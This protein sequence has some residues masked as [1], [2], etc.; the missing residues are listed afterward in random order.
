M[1]QQWI[2]SEIVGF[3]DATSRWN[4]P[5]SVKIICQRERL[6]VRFPLPADIDRVELQFARS[7][8]DR[9]E[10][11]TRNGSVSKKDPA[12]V[13][14]FEIRRDS[15]TTPTLCY[16]PVLLPWIVDVL[17]SAVKRAINL[18]KAATGHGWAQSK[19][20]VKQAVEGH[21]TGT[22]G[23]LETRRDDVSRLTVML[24]SPYARVSLPAPFV[25]PSLTFVHARCAPRGFQRKRSNSRTG[26]A[27]LSWCARTELY[28]SRR[29]SSEYWLPRT[30]KHKDGVSRDGD[31]TR[32]LRLCFPNI[33]PST[34]RLARIDHVY[35]LRFNGNNRA[36]LR[37]RSTMARVMG[38]YGK[39]SSGNNSCIRFFLP[40]RYV[41]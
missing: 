21:F 28:D 41:I 20:E 9:F 31:E 12:S 14:S 3:N 15:Y 39:Y 10:F 24:L 27:V 8:T 22:E 34:F 35:R 16:L 6:A 1:I 29:R 7:T 5:R 32:E 40:P 23:V 2:I 25:Y 36:S 19:M 38:L 4:S 11:S 18:A 26:S 33:F 13:I 30:R 37:A 17:R